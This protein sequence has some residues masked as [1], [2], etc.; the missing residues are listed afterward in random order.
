MPKYAREIRTPFEIEARKGRDFAVGGI[1]GFR[2]DYRQAKPCYYMRWSAEGKI[3]NVFI[4]TG[5]SLKDAKNEARRIREII[6][7]GLD[8]NEI[9]KAET[10]REREEERQKKEEEAKRLNTLRVV[11]ERFFEHGKEAGLWRGKD[12]GDNK[13]RRF[14]NSRC[15]KEFGDTPI[16]EI[17]PEK[18]CDHFSLYWVSTPAQADKIHGTLNQIFNWAVAKRIS[19]LETNPAALTGP[20]GVL[21]RPLTLKR[22]SSKNLP[23]P[24][25][26]RMRE[27]LSE[28]EPYHSNS[29][30]AFIFQVLTA[31]RGEA[32]RTLE[33]TDIDLENRIAVIQ[34]QNDKGSKEFNDPNRPREIFLSEQVIKLLEG[35]P[36][37]SRFVFFSREGGGFK[38]IGEGAIPQFLTGLHERKKREDGIGWVDENYLDAH[39]FPK[40]IVPH[41]TARATFR[42]WC[43]ETGKNDRAA[44]LCLFH[45]HKDLYKGAYNRAEFREE[46]RAMM[47]EWSDY[48]LHGLDLEKLFR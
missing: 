29:K 6:D 14:M 30:K 19:N 2:C 12:K 28:C 1:E 42:T 21:I 41:G 44:E 26:R 48:C 38:H 20:F 39:G 46:R 23:A 7:Q 22:E 3:K 15:L 25:Y 36:R 45:L 37:V 17:T 18:L 32:T 9:R 33:W 27:L 43:A 34:P 16:S 40:K 11:A 10:A 47:Q 8:P 35:I 5:Y 24:D 31:T 13:I 4:G